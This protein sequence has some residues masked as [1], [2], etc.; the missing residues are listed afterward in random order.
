MGLEEIAAVFIPGLRRPRPA[1][2]SHRDGPG[3]AQAPRLGDAPQSDKGRG[4]PAERR[5]A[6]RP[7]APFLS[8]NDIT[9][10]NRALGVQ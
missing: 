2:G 8:I 1:C 3:E 7:V 10:S 5:C 9:C 6:S 4:P